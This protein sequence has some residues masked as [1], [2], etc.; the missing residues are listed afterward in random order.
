MKHQHWRGVRTLFVS[1]GASMLHLRPSILMTAPLEARIELLTQR[2]A[3]SEL[4]G[5]RQL[6]GGGSNSP[7]T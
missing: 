2:N 6:A 5:E 1:S 7:L 4:N 3:Y